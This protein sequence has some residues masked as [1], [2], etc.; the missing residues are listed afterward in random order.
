[1]GLLARVYVVFYAVLNC[2]RSIRIES[3]NRLIARLLLLFALLGNLVPIALAANPAPPHACCLRKGV[4]HCQ[5]SSGSESSQPVVRDSSCC[6]GNCGH[7]VTTAQWAHPQPRLA[8]FALQ[9]SY[10]GPAAFQSQT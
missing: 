8:S 7:A 2:G 1:M 10:T 6:R 3:M 5:D 4:H 9:I